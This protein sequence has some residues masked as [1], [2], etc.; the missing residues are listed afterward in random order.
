M[1]F[2]N[3]YCKRCGEMYNN[4][5]IKLCKSCHI[6]SAN[7]IIGN[8]NEK[9]NEK[10]NDLIQ[11]IQLKITNSYDI[12]PEWIPYNQFSNIV[13]ISKDDF[14]VLYSAIW[15]D[16]PLRYNVYDN[17]KLIRES[18]EIVILKYFFNSQNIT[19]EFLNEVWIF[20]LKGIQF[21]I[22]IFFCALLIGQKI[23]N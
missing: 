6:K 9:I 3:Q 13:E 12:V 18:D 22:L 17:K 2:K 14:S 23:F 1:V 15:R 11:E 16:G 5:H 20:N 8:K 19:D 10:I 21:M 4:I 7:I